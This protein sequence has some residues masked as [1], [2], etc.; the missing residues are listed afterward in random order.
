VT[1][2]RIKWSRLGTICTHFLPK[3]K[4]NDVELWSLFPRDKFSSAASVNTKKLD[5]S[6]ADQSE[7][8]PF[9]QEKESGR[10]IR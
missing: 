8:H 6:S 9:R 2:V 7:N 4:H 1:K 5:L 10:Q 3:N